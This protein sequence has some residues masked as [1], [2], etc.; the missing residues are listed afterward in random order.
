MVI[1]KMIIQLKTLGDWEGPHHDRKND[2]S[3]R[4]KKCKKMPGG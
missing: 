2:D 1:E 4:G 3:I